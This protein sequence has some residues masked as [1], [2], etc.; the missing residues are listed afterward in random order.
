MKTIE[1]IYSICMALLM[2]SPIVLIVLILKV[3][4]GI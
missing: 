2:L 4:F 1:I 3:G